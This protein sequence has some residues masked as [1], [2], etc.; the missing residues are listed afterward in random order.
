[1][2]LFSA[3]VTCLPSLAQAARAQTNGG[4]SGDAP[5]DYVPQ[6]ESHC[7]K[8]DAE[9]CDPETSV[10]TEEDRALFEGLAY[11][12]ID[13][14]Y[15]VEATFESDAPSRRPLSTTMGGTRPFERA[16][17]LTRVRYRHVSCLRSETVDHRVVAIHL[18]PCRVLRRRDGREACRR[19]YILRTGSG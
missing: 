15:R 8:I 12:D 17:I 9:L 13:P 10:L 16:G 3:R 1:M 14:S 6:I 2:V 5:S 4:P 19:R 7:D 18:Q 11:F